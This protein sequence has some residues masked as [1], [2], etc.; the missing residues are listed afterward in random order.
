MLTSAVHTH[1]D[2]G[3]LTSK[4]IFN[5]CRCRRLSSA[6]V[7]GCT[8]TCGVVVAVISCCGLPL[9][10]RVAATAATHRN[11]IQ[12]TSVVRVAGRTTAERMHFH[13]PSARSHFG[14]T[15]ARRRTEARRPIDTRRRG[16]RVPGIKAH[17]TDRMAS[18]SVF[19]SQRALRTQHSSRISTVSTHQ[20][21][22]PLSTL[23]HSLST[24]VVIECLCLLC[25]RV[26]VWAF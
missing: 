5:D 22:E 12:R 7:F 1:I 8:C 19:A 24:S 16:H 21:L 26:F 6:V 15:S 23:S 20:V 17:T 4:C 18:Y 3:H 13:F 2:K 25:V 10:R 14:C 11:A 9:R